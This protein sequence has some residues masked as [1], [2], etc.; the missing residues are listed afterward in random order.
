MITIK[1]K[2]YYINKDKIKYAQRAAE[3]EGGFLPLIPLILG[4][5]AAAG[6]VAGGAAGITKAVQ[7][8]KAHDA[9]LA[10]QKR[11]NQN[12]E[13]AA[14]GN[15][16]ATSGNGISGEG[17]EEVG[18]QIGDGFI[19]T[20]QAIKNFVKQIPDIPDEGKKILKQTLYNLS[21]AV[22]VKAA[23]GNGLMLSPW[24]PSN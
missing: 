11:H 21:N 6:S 7:D 8:K 24:T 16:V 23:E 12:L 22:N 1:G 14:R 3:A 10:E 20:K 2:K 18:K 13:A 17:L 9:A 5:I 15:G 4:G 19:A